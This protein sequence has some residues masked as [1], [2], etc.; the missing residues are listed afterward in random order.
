MTLSFA[1]LSRLP[2]NASAFLLLMSVNHPWVYELYMA[3]PLAEAVLLMQKFFWA[4]T[5]DD[6]SKIADEFPPDL[7][8]RGLI[9]LGVCLVLLRLAQKLFSRLESKFPERL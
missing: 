3:N 2:E 9:M 5:V 6:Q 7:W 8:E 4:G 1:E